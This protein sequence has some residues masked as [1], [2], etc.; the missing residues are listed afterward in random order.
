MK[1]TRILQVFYAECQ[2]SNISANSVSSIMP[3]KVNSLFNI[4]GCGH[5]FFVTGYLMRFIIAG[6]LLG[7]PAISVPVSRECCFVYNDL[8]S[9]SST[10]F[11]S[12][13]II[14]ITLR[15]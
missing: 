15:R 8:T 11:G 3:E 4:Y 9:L 5:S 12:L 2:Y 10:C 6:N 14:V 1:F 7:L 13:C